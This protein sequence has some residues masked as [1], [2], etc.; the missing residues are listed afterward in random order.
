MRGFTLLEV[1]VALVIV[2]MGMMAVFTQLNQSLSAAS[3]L[4]DKT[5]ANWV[6][7]DRIT[8]IRVTGEYPKVGRREDEVEMANTV[9]AYAIDVSQVD[10]NL[11]RLDVTVSFADTPDEILAEVAGFVAPA[12]QTPPVTISWALP[13]DPDAIPTEGQEQ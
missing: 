5:L 1:L 8:E 2:G 7:V 13:L 12:E 4:R 10:E 3:R 6:A 9:W 11:R